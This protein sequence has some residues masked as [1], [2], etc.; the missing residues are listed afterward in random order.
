MT[1]LPRLTLLATLLAGTSVHAE[2]MVFTPCSELHAYVG[3]AQVVNARDN[4]TGMYREVL[5]PAQ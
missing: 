3:T 2:P 4:E 5:A 1:F